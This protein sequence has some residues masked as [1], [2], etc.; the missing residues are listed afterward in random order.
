MS[1][2]TVILTPSKMIIHIFGLYS[3]I[4][5]LALGIFIPILLFAIVHKHYNGKNTGDHL[6]RSAIYA[7]IGYALFNFAAFAGPVLE[8][9]K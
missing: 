5:I 6:L 4:F 2:A 7:I 3:T 8:A 9:I 1:L